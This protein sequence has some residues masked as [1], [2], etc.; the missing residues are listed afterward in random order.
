MRRVLA[1]VGM[2]LLLTGLLP[3]LS[4]SAATITVST[5]RATTPSASSTLEI[6]VTSSVDVTKVTLTLV[7][8]FNGAPEIVA[9]GLH[10]VSGG[11]RDGVWRTDTPVALPM[12]A[13]N[14]R[15]AVTDADDVTTTVGAGVVDNRAPTRFSEFSVSPVRM[16]VDHDVLTY[17]GRV[18]YTD[19]GGTE[20]PVPQGTVYMTLNT[21]SI[22]VPSP[23]LDADGRFSGTVRLTSVGAY[24]TLVEGYAQAIFNGASSV[25]APA[26]GSSRIYVHV[27]P[28]ETRLTIKT[29]PAQLIVGGNATITGRLERHTSSGEWAAAPGQPVKISFYDPPRQTQ[30]SVGQGT[31]K[32][33]GSYA[34]PVVVPGTG[35]WSVSFS[36]SYDQGPLN[37]WGLG[38]YQSS[39][40][41]TD[42]YVNARYISKV[43]GFKAGPSPIAK[44]STWLALQGRVV[45]TLPD[46]TVVSSRDAFVRPEFSTDG[47]TWHAYGTVNV[48][49]D[50]GNFRFY[51]TAVRDGY[52]RVVTAGAEELPAVSPAQY[53]DVRYRTAISSFNASPEPVRKGRTL[54][55]SGKLSRYVS[56]WGA[57][58]G[59][60][61]Y[62]YFQPKGSTTFGYVGVTTTSGTGT[63]RKGFTAAK[64]GTWRVAFK[65]TS[66]YLGVTSGGDYVDVN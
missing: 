23:T 10:R 66:Q 21:A 12:G 46:G 57:F 6:T 61:I 3:V 25:Y 27:I 65:A 31:T 1:V 7:P 17:S 43:V 64:D 33:D 53:V 48:D 51:E 34:V 8:R 44:G 5:V 56:S 28:Q 37:S 59:Q 22:A 26:P 58:G 18:V 19:F 63:F 38:A 52:W 39:Y 62:V 11:P 13:M 36:R 47:K 42:L 14:V 54:T 4:A 2:F 35:Q 32:D 45:N 60:K 40:A 9:D 29:N 20:R 24:P 41:A 16:D 50:A 15:V 49:D 30:V 55:V